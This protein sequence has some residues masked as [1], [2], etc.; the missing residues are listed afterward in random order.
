MGI[1]RN[2]IWEEE[3]RQTVRR[4]SSDL[5]LGQRMAV[6]PGIPLTLL[7][8]CRSFSPHKCS[9]AILLSY[10]DAR[11]SAWSLTVSW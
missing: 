2:R 8:S 9:H 5:L 4:I 10:H 11:A 6:P 3:R 7:S 1:D